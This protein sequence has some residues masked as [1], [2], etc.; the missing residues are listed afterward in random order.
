MLEHDQATH[1]GQQSIVWKFSYCVFNP[2]IIIIVMLWTHCSEGV[3]EMRN[4]SC[5]CWAG[6]VWW[7]NLGLC[8]ALLQ[9][10]DWS[11]AISF[12]YGHAKWDFLVFVKPAVCLS[13]W[14]GSG[15]QCRKIGFHWYFLSGVFL[16]LKDDRDRFG[17]FQVLK[18]PVNICENAV[19]V[20]ITK[21]LPPT[22]SFFHYQTL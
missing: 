22:H 14:K 12:S 7:W 3:A 15:V 17:G 4:W 20:D 2:F 6:A 18:E 21:L 8:W 19:Y 10:A 11:R 5:G 1:L 16:W 13:H 9:V